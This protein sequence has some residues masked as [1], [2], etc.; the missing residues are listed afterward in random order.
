MHT[1][2]LG[3]LAKTLLIVCTLVV[4]LTLSF[5]AVSFKLVT[6]KFQELEVDEARLNLERVVNDVGD[7]RKKLETIV[8]DWAPWDDTYIFIRELNQEFIE[9]NLS[10]EGFQTLGLD[11]MLFFDDSNQLV[12]SRFFYPHQPI[13]T[14]PDTSVIYAL[15]AAPSFFLFDSNQAKKSG[16]IRSKTTPVFV[17]S[18]PIVTSTYEGPARGTLVIGR[19]LDQAKIEQIGAQTRVKLEAFA[20]N[21]EYQRLFNSADNGQILI[22]STP[23]PVAYRELDARHLR[24]FTVINDLLDHPSLVFA[25]TL[26][27]KLLQQGRAMWKD[28]ASS[29]ILLGIVFISVLTL[30]LNRI[31]LRRLTRLGDEVNQVAQAG[32]HD[33]R[34]TA[35]QHDEIGSLAIGIN[36][37]LA[38]LETLQT[39]QEKNEQHLRDIIDSINCGIMLVDPQDRRILSINQTGAAMAGR[40][41][42]EMTGQHCHQFICPNERHNCPVLDQKETIDLSERTILHADGRT[43]PVLKSVRRIEREGQTLLVESFINISELKAMQVELAA[44]EAKYRQFFEEDLTG[45]F[46]S[47]SEGILLDCNPAFAEILGYSSPAQIIGKPMTGHYIHPDKRQKLLQRVIEKG[48][49]ERYEGVLRHRNGQP[50]YIV[51]NVIGEFDDQR[52][53]QRIRG[54]VFDDTKRVILEKEIRQ[55][56]KL[57]AV[58]TMAG[59]IAHDFNNILGGIIGYAEIVL[60]DLDERQAPKSCHYLRNILSAGERARDL[61][62]KILTFSRQSESQR[63]P[64]N[65]ARTLEDVLHLIRVSLPSSITIIPSI[66]NPP[67]VKADPIQ[68]HQVLMNLCTNAGYAMKEEGGTLSIFLETVQLDADFTR[69]HPELTTGEYAK[70]RIE[71][72]GKGIPAPLLDRIFDPF[73]TTKPKGEGTGLGLSM[74]HGIVKAMHGLI[75]VESQEGRGTSFTIYLPTV[76]EEEVMPTLMQHSIPTGQEHVVYVDDEGFLVDIGSEILRDLGYKVSGFTDSQEALD[77]LLQNDAKVDLIISDMTMPKLSG[78]ELAKRLQS[79][80]APPPVIICTGHSEGLTQTDVAHIGIHQLLLKPVT[81]NKLAQAVR[82]VLDNK[83]IH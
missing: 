7:S 65:L 1:K 63:T 5:L 50:I 52:Q 27:R 6:D 36:E 59:G 51:C 16:I 47:S 72:T 81:V 39:L 78:I 9:K 56:Q 42:E 49:L 31:I 69:R 3:I 43:I 28:H 70:I 79:L 2:H 55:A 19:Y 18:A 30:L 4:V 71:D 33:L 35:T 77:Y 62:E 11:F 58:G 24:A 17:A 48:R 21:Q 12:Y 34:V 40:K 13:T 38:S 80:E 29:L 67:T 82:E 10:K 23:F 25:V 66:T 61:I 8:G 60:R 74:V 37:M 45:N 64:V 75:H 26:E 32:R 73:F 46:L 20:Y 57:E 44:S 15:K 22:D 41:P 68:I 83:V 54:Y 53:L 76:K 14:S